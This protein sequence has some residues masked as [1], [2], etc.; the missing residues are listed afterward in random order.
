MK[1]YKKVPARKMD[2]SSFN[3]WIYLKEFVIYHST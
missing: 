3:E 2:N 1:T